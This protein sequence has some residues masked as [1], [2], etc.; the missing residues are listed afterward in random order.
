MIGAHCIRELI[1]MLPHLLGD[2]RQPRANIERAAKELSAAW[3]NAG[4]RPP[5]AGSGEDDQAAPRA[6]PHTVYRAAFDVVAVAVEGTQ[7]SRRLTATIATGESLAAN[8]PQIDR[9]HREI[10]KFRR[11]CHRTDYTRPHVALP[12]EEEVESAL[13]TI[14]HA[15]LGRLGNMADRVA[16]VLSAVEAANRRGSE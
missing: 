3:E 5:E 10:E 11:W 15:L 16:V 9:L 12:P 1:A 4:L 8:A 2:Q 7:N 13:N 14:E 6:V